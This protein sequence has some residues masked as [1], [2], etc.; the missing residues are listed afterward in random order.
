ME[1]DIYFKKQLKRFQQKHKKTKGNDVHLVKQDGAEAE[2]TA[3][4]ESNEAEKTT[5][6]ESNEAEKTTA[7]E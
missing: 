6:D 7:N 2:K 3:S 4:D 5:A 1:Q